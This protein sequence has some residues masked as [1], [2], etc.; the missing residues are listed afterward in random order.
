VLFRGL[1]AVLHFDFCPGPKLVKLRPVSKPKQQ[2]RAN[3]LNTAQREA[4][5][6]PVKLNAPRKWLFRLVAALAVPLVF[7]ALI[8][9]GLRLVGF[10]YPTDFFLKKEI[11]G[12]RVWVE[13][14]QFGRSFFPTELARS[15]SPLVMPA[16][17][18]AD[19]C[20]IFVLGES[21]ALG[22]PEP[23]FGF[24]RY[25]QVLLQDR[26]PQQ[27]FEVVCTAMTAINSHVILPI[28]R[29]CAR[30]RGDIW[31]IYMGNN[32]F[33]GPFGPGTVFGPEVPPL[34][35]IRFGTVLKKT[36]LGQ[37]LYRMASKPVSQKNWGGMKMFLDH[38]VPPDDP[39]KKTVYQY[40]RSN[41]E[42]ILAAAK[43]GGARV[44]LSTVAANLKDCPPFGS[45][46]SRAIGEE[47]T[48]Q[49]NQLFDSGVKAQKSG[50]F[51]MA[52]TNYQAAAQIDSSFAELQ[53]RWAQCF[54]ALTNAEEAR[55]HFELARDAD[56][57]PF[58]AD[59]S[60]NSIIKEAATKHGAD[61]VTFVDG[62]RV[63][64]EKSAEG[65]VGKESMYEHVH[66]NFEGNYQLAYAVAQSI[67]GLL[68][69]TAKTGN[70]SDWMS[71]E[72]SSRRLALTPWDRRRVYESLVRRLAEPP[73]VNQLG[74]A[75]QMETLKQMVL[76]ERARQ[77]P[78]T[79]QPTRVIY[80]QA[81][82]SQPGDVYLLGDYGKFD[83]DIGDLPGAAQQWKAASEEVPFT[84]GPHYYLGK[85]LGRQGKLEEGLQELS[86]ALTIRPDLPEALEEKGRLLVA[87]KRF[88]E[89]MKTLNRAAELE[90][91][92]ARICLDRA[93]AL[94]ANGHQAE[95]FAQLKQAVTLQPTSWEARYL[96]GVELAFRGELRPAA[97][98][99]IET[100]RLNPNYPLAHLNLGIA[101]AKLDRVDDAIAQFEQTIT[102]D[103]KNQKA[104]EYLQALRAK[105]RHSQ[106]STP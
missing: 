84:P 95:A 52:F 16:E 4:P 66:L 60:L 62:E 33:V 46:H 12:K 77:T 106:K 15:P 2:K 40:F 81:I 88:D 24:G 27:R 17:K 9:V 94:A 3:E 45:Q 1:G 104:G 51:P 78:D 92:S 72:A 96:L 89:G 18:P 11:K 103:P 82:T 93:Q 98:Q 59:D 99:F 14:D 38:Q 28:A 19:V 75:G 69:E 25:L 73:F 10:G 70:R 63:L 8:E 54:L 35:M 39:R 80:E 74:H 26:F 71:F 68:P 87:A 97:E 29:E 7:L 34:G 76:A 56:T 101:L 65:I 83:E 32:E 42:D 13:N 61:G 102:L 41:L 20:R 37:L 85:V 6:Q 49:W 67:V 21:A 79:I 36:R 22:D 48:N 90:P 86:E 100:I 30:R 5:V 64:A 55:R 47:Q 23:A 44:V 53:F 31:V 57:L 105:Q 58:R 91:G 43:G 50:N